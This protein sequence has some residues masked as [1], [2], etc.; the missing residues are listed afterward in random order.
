MTITKAINQMEG[1]KKRQ[2][3]H[4]SD[5]MKS[6]ATMGSGGLLSQASHEL[7]FDTLQGWTLWNVGTMPDYPLQ[8]WLATT[9]AVGTELMP[10][11]IA[12]MTNHS[13]AWALASF[14][15][16]FRTLDEKRQAPPTSVM[17]RVD[18]KSI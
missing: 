1:M 10:D 11:F 6:M 12:T 14:H 4:E 7:V 2:Q 3:T 13:R 17:W 8:V 16:D 9:L 5:A 15:E 18:M